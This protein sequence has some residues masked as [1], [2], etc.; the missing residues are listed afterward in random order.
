[1]RNDTLINLIITLGILMTIGVV[2]LF[3]SEIGC[4]EHIEIKVYG[5]CYKGLCDGMDET[6]KFYNL[7]NVCVEEKYNYISDISAGILIIS[8]FALIIGV[9]IG[10]LTI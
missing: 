3:Y 1:M 4:E 5:D 8:L 2:G 9:F 6:G 7:K 10:V